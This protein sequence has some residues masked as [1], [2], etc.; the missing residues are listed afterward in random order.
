M[1][2]AINSKINL[3]TQESAHGHQV[4]RRSSGQ[5]DN[6]HLRGPNRFN[7]AFA[8]YLV[9]NPNILPVSVAVDYQYGCRIFKLEGI[10]DN[11]NSGIYTVDYFFKMVIPVPTDVWLDTPGSNKHGTIFPS[12]P[13]THMSSPGY[14]PQSYDFGG[15]GKRNRFKM[16]LKNLK[17]QMKAWCHA[18]S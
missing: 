15:A 12:R 14:V 3:G 16:L 8:P 13:T 2:A 1:T 4:C 7:F 18:G 5:P 9:E 10:W 11:I 6:N 17:F